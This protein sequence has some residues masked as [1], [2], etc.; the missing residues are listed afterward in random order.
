[1][2]LFKGYSKMLSNQYFDRDGNEITEEE[3]RTKRLDSTYSVVGE[4]TLLANGEKIVV[5]TIWVGEGYQS[6]S[7]RLYQSMVFNGRNNG[8][9]RYYATEL[10]ALIGHN[11]IVDIVQD[12]LY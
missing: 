1:M 8:L 5:S 10:E 2:E 11:E 3:W 7:Q 6:N 9:T 12:T 4:C